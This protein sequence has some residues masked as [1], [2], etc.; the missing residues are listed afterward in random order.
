MALEISEAQRNFALN[1]IQTGE[2]TDAAVTSAKLAT[3]IQTLLGYIDISGSLSTLLSGKQNTEAGKGLSTND[4]TASYKT[5]LDFVGSQ[6]VTTLVNI[7]VT[8]SVVYASINSNQALSMNGQVPQGRC[9]HVLVKS[10]SA[11]AV[12]IA[13]PNA[14]TYSPDNET[15]LT[16]DAQG[17][18]ELNVMY[19]SRESLTKIIIIK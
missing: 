9:I 11:S 17:R 7:P 16:I 2:I 14:G 8:K 19:D 10:S 4:F 5:L 13:I 6:T 18:A 3:A 15:S 1:P 12:T